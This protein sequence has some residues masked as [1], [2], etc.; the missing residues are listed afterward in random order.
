LKLKKLPQWARER[1]ARLANNVKLRLL[2]CTSPCKVNFRKIEE[3]LQNLAAK[4][5][6][7]AKVLHSI[8]DVL[9][10]LP[11]GLKK[12][13]ISRKLRKKNS[14]LWTAIREADLTDADFG[15]LADFLTPGDLASQAQAYRTFVRYL[16]GVVPSKTGKDIRKLNQILAK[17]VKAEPRRAAALKG[18]MFEQWIALHVPQLAS[19]TFGRITF[20]VR[21]LLKKILPPYR[22]HVDKWVPDKGEIWDMKHQLSKVPTGQADD[23]AGLV[24][25]TAPDGNMVKSVNYIFPS[26]DA[27][28]LNKHLAT[29][30]KFGVYYID[31]VTNKLTKLM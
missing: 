16:T 30:Y 23:Y 2:G 17:M 4:G 28:V 15:K 3:Y 1:F 21:K 13:K 26:K 10:A 20:D 22:R 8:D 19:R 27:A 24:G 14:A 31:E 25:K 29:T 12:A 7:G 6:K 11:R 5:T 18:S 9:A